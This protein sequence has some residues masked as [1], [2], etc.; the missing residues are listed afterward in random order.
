M[1]VDVSSNRLS[2]TNLVTRVTTPR[3][4][5]TNVQAS[6]AVSLVMIGLLA[7]LKRRGLG[8]AAATAGPSLV[9]STHYR[10]VTG[11]LAHSLD[12]L[13]LSHDAL[14]HSC[15]RLCA[16]AEIVCVE[17]TMGLF[18]SRRI[19]VTR[20]T[21]TKCAGGENAES[22]QIRRD[23]DIA[24]AIGAP[25]I[26]VVDASRSIETIGALV[27][28]VKNFEPTT[29]IAGVIAINVP[30]E[31]SCERIRDTVARVAEVEFL[32]GLLQKESV[33]VQ[34][35]ND[36]PSLL[37]RSRVVELRELV[38]Q[39]ID[40][41]AIVRIAKGATELVAPKDA[42]SSNPRV[43]KIAVA[44]DAA[45]HIVV[46]D[47]LD[48]IRRA[49]GELVAFSPLADTKLPHGVWGVYLSGGYTHLYAEDLAGNRLMAEAL[50]EFAE[51]GGIIYAEG[52]SVPYLCRE[53]SVGNSAPLP[54]V[55]LIS[56]S[57]N[58]LTAA[59]D[60]GEI[61]YFDVIIANEIVIGRSGTRFKGI[62]DRR[63]VVH[64]DDGLSNKQNI[65]KRICHSLELREC[66]SGQNLN[67]DTAIL[68]GGGIC[69]SAN[70]VAC[71]VHSHW[72]SCTELATHFV[73]KVEQVTIRN[74]KS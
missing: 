35:P 71:L 5:F 58:A 67:K 45:F 52:D 57:A 53:F 24:Q 63:W 26:L 3:V 15:M 62:S 1:S 20:A 25:I 61:A 74:A 6:E 43:C 29:S 11:R 48:L 12:P 66:E 47:N 18:D 72:G 68:T 44:D 21:D 22:S 64:P 13:M 8:V 41:D 10:R 69:P 37:A 60:M 51:R 70:I 2:Q 42:L 17:G 34:A 33:F 4:F 14:V 27:L 49:G 50:R 55:G 46:Q 39:Y 36:N 38:S 23:V 9:R 19:E 59:F 28:G 16:G 7:E 54:G 31:S 65:D 30:S 56:A 32:G 40:V 73:R